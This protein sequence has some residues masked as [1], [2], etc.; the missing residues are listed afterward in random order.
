MVAHCLGSTINY[1]ALLSGRTTGKIRNLISMQVAANPMTGQYN[2]LKA[3]IYLPETLQMLGV[4]GLDAS[5]NPVKLTDRLFNAF[6]KDVSTAFFSYKER[7]QY[8]V[9]Y[10]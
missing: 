5:E 8:H 1:A 9:C 6:A 7:C 10:R 3:G 4:T 2:E